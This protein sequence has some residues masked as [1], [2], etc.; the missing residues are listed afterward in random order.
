MPLNHGYGVA[1]GTYVDFFRDPPDQFGRWYHGHLVIATPSGNYEAALDVD[2]PNGGIS[3]RLV[4]DLSAADLGPVGSLGPGFHLLASSPASGALDYV[5]STS[6]RD[7]FVVVRIRS[8]LRLWHA[9]WL[10]RILGRLKS[11]FDWLP[12]LRWRSF[13]W[14]PSNGDDTLTVLEGLLP[15]A[16]RIYIFGEPFTQGLGV[17][18]VHQN[19]GDPPGEHQAENGVWQDGAVAIRS[20]ADRVTIWQVKFN[21]QSLRTDDNGLPLP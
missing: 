13:P 15:T 7:G 4:E 1:V 18:N 16:A 21:T 3:Y 11:L 19:Q 6:L 20:A 5:R 2:K 8:R 14:V 9:S 12:L 17:H 10:N